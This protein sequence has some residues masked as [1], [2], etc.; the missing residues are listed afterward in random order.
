MLL[1]NKKTNDKLEKRIKKYNSTFYREIVMGLLALLSVGTIIF[2]LSFSVSERT[3]DIIFAMDLIIAFVF[4]SEYLWMLHRAKTKGKFFIKNLHLLL[5][6]I[7]IVDSWAEIF[8]ALRLFEV[9]RVFR[10]GEHVNFTWH[11]FIRDNSGLVKKRK[12]R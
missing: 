11:E 5:A 1:Q 12:K 4:M 9:V 3:A 6:S 7:P 2:E 10:A 8:R